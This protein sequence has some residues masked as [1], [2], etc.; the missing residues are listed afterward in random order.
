M[1]GAIRNPDSAD[2]RLLVDGMSEPATTTPAQPT[3]PQGTSG[4]EFLCAFNEMRNQLVST[5]YYLLGNF[6][7]AQDAVQ[8]TFIKCWRSQ[9]ELV[10]ISNVRAWIYR[11]GLNAAKDLQRNAWR[12]RAKPLAG[13]I[14]L[15]EAQGLS[16][17]K[18]LE[19]KETIERLRVALFDLRP[20]EKE[21]FLLRLHGGLTYEDIAALRHSPVGTVKTQMRAAV[22]K[23]RLVFEEE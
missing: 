18:A 10:T 6:E 14:A 4:E 19:E 20:A 13:T 23:L 11:V 8:E 22:A 9:A 15:L 7:D 21:V 12:R 16:P 1:W 5:L 2:I 17:A 3:T